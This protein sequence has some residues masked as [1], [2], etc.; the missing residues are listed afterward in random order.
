MALSQ[1][2][3]QTYNA[4]LNFTHRN[5]SAPVSTHEI[6]QGY[7][8]AT[9]SS[10]GVAVLLKSITP[11]RYS[12]FIAYPAVAVGNI[13]NTMFMRK[14]E[15]QSGITVTGFPATSTPGICGMSPAAAQHAVMSTAVSR[16]ILPMPAFLVAPMVLKAMERVLQRPAP[17]AVVVV[18]QTV[19]LQF[20]IPLT[21]AMFPEK[22]EMHANQVEA[23]VATRCPQAERFVYEKGL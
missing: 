12:Y 23:D 6:A 16:A 22:G 18:L 3:N 5:K 17:L 19:A 4:A 13:F 1:G 8:A 10:M 15:L 2:A 20:G 9:G 14:A 7:C 21:L 11:A